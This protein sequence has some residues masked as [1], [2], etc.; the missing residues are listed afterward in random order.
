L[1]I[2]PCPNWWLCAWEPL[3]WQ[4]QHLMEIRVCLK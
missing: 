4:N 2:T 1:H 3:W